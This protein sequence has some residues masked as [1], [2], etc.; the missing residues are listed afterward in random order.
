MSKA[1][2]LRTLVNERLTAAAEEIF[3]L[4]ERTI[5]EYEEELCRSKEE[6]Q[7]KQQ[8]LDSL[9]NPQP[10]TAAQGAPMD[11]FGMKQII[12][13]TL[14][15]KEEPEEQEEEQLPEFTVVCVKSE[16]RELTD[17]FSDADDEEEPPAAQMKTEADGE[18]Y[19]QVQIKDTNTAAH[20]SG[21]FNT[22]RCGAE[23]RDTGAEGH[24]SDIDDDDDFDDEEEN[25]RVSVSVLSKEF[26]G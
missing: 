4:V 21:L 12:P 26:D 11:T 19:T 7:R 5:V 8:L 1:F 18:H 2:A 16:E 22:Y 13:E 23:S 10:H 17:S 24:L 3:A 15:I 6:N 25:M 9:L 20:N 14:Q